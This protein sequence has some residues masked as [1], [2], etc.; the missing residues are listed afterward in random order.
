MKIYMKKLSIILIILISIVPFVVFADTGQEMNGN[1]SMMENMMGWNIW[2]LG[3]GL[4][5]MISVWVLV[6]LGI[7]VLIKW[8]IDSGKK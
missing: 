8:L 6:I 5:F 7:I 1:H 2:G 4:I 3:F